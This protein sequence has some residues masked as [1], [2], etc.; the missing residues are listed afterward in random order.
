MC[1][2]TGWVS[3]ERDLRLERETI[4]AMTSSM[5]LRGPDAGGTW[6]GRHVGLGHRR[7]AVI[8]LAGGVQPMVAEGPHGRVVIV[9]SGEVYNFLELRRELESR[10]HRFTT[11]SDT[12]VVLRAYLE[13]GAQSTERLN[14]MFAFAIWDEG[15]SQLTLVRDR[16]GIKPLYYFPTPDGMVFGSEP[17]AI[18]ANRAALRAVDADG[19]A[20]LFPEIRTPGRSPWKGMHEV[21]P[22]TSVIVGR[23]GMTTHAYWR[24][25]VKEH[26][27]DR[28]T[29]VERVRDLMA[30]TVGRQLVADVPQCVLL[31]GGLD[32]SAVAGLA[33]AHLASAGETLRTFSVDFVGHADNFKPSKIH[34]TQDTPFARQVAEHVGTA[35]S[36]I[37]LDL[38]E[39]T[40]PDVRR[41]VVAARDMPG[42]GQLD[43]SLYQLF[44]AI[45][46]ESTV[47]LSG[48]SA[49]ELFG[50]YPWFHDE[51][52]CR[53]DTFP[54]LAWRSSS[55]KSPSP[56]TF[57]LRPDV[58]THI[59]IRA[60]TAAQYSSAV[61][62]IEHVDGASD[63][64]RRM[65]V[66][67]HLALTRMVRTWLDR[68]DRV[69]M[70]V[71]LEVRVPYCDHRL[72]EYVYNVP[73]PLKT[74]DGREKSL[75]RHATQHV[76]PPSVV[77]RR[78]SGYP[79][80]VDPRYRT[81]LQQ[82]AKDILTEEQHS[83]FDIVSVDWLRTAAQYDVNSLPDNFLEG[84]GIVLDLYHWIDIYRP[85]LSLP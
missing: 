9:Y 79:A 52:A 12:E 11:S 24:L 72:V 44:K 32:S 82:Q 60:R 20:E 69:S 66:V 28:A 63:I 46:Q 3:F 14:G 85:T 25:P 55:Q 74:F 30:D 56:L 50:G 1:G 15:T 42:L 22:G 45:R 62:Q 23:G 73:W 58:L 49:D 21:Q 81:A 70:A 80:T 7:L 35:H 2:I 10:R 77:Q 83:V 71:G 34:L 36:N 16:L 68:K 37:V 43:A 40:D 61:A 67:N 65:R 41:S 76:L 47:A 78:K 8:D 59:D 84:I 26:T 51:A 54:W 6:L 64:A 33:S 13:W 39:I 17:K 53:A 4:D 48:E 27:D 57:I 31:S 18:L 38:D 5:M 75:L 29:T 19:L